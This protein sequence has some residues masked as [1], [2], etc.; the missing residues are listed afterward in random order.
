[1]KVSQSAPPPGPSQVPPKIR[2]LSR[3]QTVTICHRTRVYQ[4]GNWILRDRQL[5]TTARACVSGLLSVGFLFLKTTIG[6]KSGCLK[7]TISS[8]QGR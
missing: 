3:R 2:E 8:R 6:D 7:A 1:M 4:M 5:E